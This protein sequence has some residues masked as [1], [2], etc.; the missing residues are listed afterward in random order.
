MDTHDKAWE[1]SAATLTSGQYSR[2]FCV[3]EEG[4]REGFVGI[5]MIF[6]P[7]LLT[8]PRCVQGSLPTEA[9]GLDCLPKSPPFSRP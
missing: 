1:G 8:F 2:E 5:K 7:C 4:I 3:P 6:Q 9:P